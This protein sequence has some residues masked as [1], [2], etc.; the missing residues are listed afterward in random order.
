[1]IKDKKRPTAYDV[2]RLAGVSQSMVSRAFTP[3]ASISADAK[4]RVLD[5]AR[6]LNYRPNLIARSLITQSSRLIGVAMAYMENQFYPTVLEALSKDFME[7]GYR[8][9]LFTPGPDGNPD[10][11]LDEV[12]RFQVEAIIL[13]ST[14]MTSHFVDEC[15]QVGVPVILFNRRTER[16]DVS[17]VTGQN[18]EGGK[19]IGSYL[20]AGEHQNFAYVAGIE[21][22]STSRERE[23]GF[24]QALV[25]GGVCD[26]QKAVGHYDFTAAQQAAR[27]L[28]SSAHAPDAIFCANDHMAFAVMGVAQTEFGLRI[29]HDVSIVGFDDVH[30]AAWPQFQLTTYSQPVDVMAA[31]LVK[32]VVEFLDGTHAGPIQEIVPGQLVIRESTRKPART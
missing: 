23:Q 9:L 13:A 26:Y 24:A 16:A 32:L 28:F 3:G 30:L 22:A 18:I 1:M 4:I 10:P 27:H 2:A 25:Q 5:A 29:G 19:T 20:L 12:L 14:H 6:T 21:D 11:I 7:H 31:R 8:L 17:S 15:T